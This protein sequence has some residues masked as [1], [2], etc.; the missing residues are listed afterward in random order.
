MP[1]VTPVWIDGF[2]ESYDQAYAAAQEG[3]NGNLLEGIPQPV[4]TLD[5]IKEWLNSYR[6]TLH[7]GVATDRLMLVID[8]QNAVVDTMLAQVQAWRREKGE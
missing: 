6:L 3:M 1:E 7:R 5:Q 8:T 2:Y 4:M